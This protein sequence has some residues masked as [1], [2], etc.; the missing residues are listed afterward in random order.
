VT[1]NNLYLIGDLPGFSPQIGRLV[2]M[3]NYT[4][5]TTLQAVAGLAVTELDYLHDPDSNSI[6]TL[7]LHIAAAEIGYQAATFD[8]RELNSEEKQV[9][10]A[11]LDLG[12]RA[13]HEIRGRELDHYLAALEQVRA[14]TLAELGRR[15]DRW[16]EEETSFGSGQRVNN[17]FKWFHVM[18]HEINHRGQ[19]RWL[20]S[21]AA[22]RAPK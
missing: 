4:R 13:R 8:S 16:L 11:A 5:S 15:D 6:G 14:K 18:G 12:D 9:W 17:Y 21:R 20:R 3:L 10:G 7:L 19:I 2:S 22:K 1:Q